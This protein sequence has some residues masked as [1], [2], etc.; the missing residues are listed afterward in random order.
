MIGK[1]LPAAVRNL[2]IA[3]GHFLLCGLAVIALALTGCATPEPVEIVVVEVTATPIPTPVVI[4]VTATPDLPATIGAMAATID[5]PTATPLPT[6]TPIP[7]ATPAPTATPLPTPTRTP[8]PTATRR[9]TATPRPTATRRPTPNPTATPSIADWSERLEPWVVLILTDDG[10]IGTGF[11]MRDPLRRS[12]WYVVTNAHVV[13]SDQFV[14]VSWAYTGIPMVKD[15][16]VLGVDEFADLAVLEVG[17]NDFDWSSTEWGNGLEYLARWG[18]GIQLSTDFRQGQEVLAMGFPDGGGG[19]TLTAG[20]IS[21][22]RVAN[23][24]YGR[25][26][27]WIK[28]DAALNPGNSGGPLMTTQG[29]IIGMNTWGRSDLENVGYALP[30]R[31]IFSRFNALKNGQSRIAVTPTPTPAPIPKADFTDGSFLAVLTWDDG[32]FNTREDGTVC[33]D[34]VTESGDWIEWQWGECLYS[35]QERD[36]SVF[37]WYQGQ[38]LE[39]YWVQLDDRPY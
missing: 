22:E 10:G 8:R 34:R 12:D 7:T 31:E 1:A 5:A 27:D 2:R 26:V 18:E 30:M 33:V 16:W 37:V 13:G 15:V 39:A 28:T 38:W 20:L 6:A 36:D 25:G 29:E 21:A 17:P 35:G 4:R 9:P 23:S 11:F 24:S 14:S 3:A 19:R 32:W